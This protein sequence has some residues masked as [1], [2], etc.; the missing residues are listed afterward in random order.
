MSYTVI[1]SKVYVNQQTGAKASI[2][3]ACPWTHPSDAENWAIRTQGFTVRNNLT[4]QV[5]TGRAP[6]ATREAAQ[7]FADTLKP[8]KICMGD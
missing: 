8:T 1:E 7:A 6:F 4:G 5:G 3:G 2:Y